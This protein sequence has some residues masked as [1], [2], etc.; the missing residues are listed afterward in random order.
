MYCILLTISSYLINIPQPH[1]RSPGEGLRPEGIKEHNG[2]AHNT[3][4]GGAAGSWCRIS[5]RISHF[6]TTLKRTGFNNSW[7][8]Q[9][10]AKTVPSSSEEMLYSLRPGRV[11][12][13]L[14]CSKRKPGVSLPP[15][16]QSQNQRCNKHRSVGVMLA[17]EKLFEK[18]F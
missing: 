10:F 12:I 4:S 17:K 14:Q 2:Y 7:K 18:F 1:Q 13:F 9:R 8:A 11:D 5:C 3:G 16:V 6:Q 15:L